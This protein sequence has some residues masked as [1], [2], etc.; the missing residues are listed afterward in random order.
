MSASLP[1]S[2][3]ILAI[4]APVL[5]LSSCRGA[6]TLTLEERLNNPLFSEY[7]YDDLVQRMV[8]IEIGSERKDNAELLGDSAR[9]S[10]MDETRRSALAAAKE[11]VGRQAE[12]RIG[13]FIPV[14]EFVKG[15]VLLLPEALYFGPD[16]DAS[17]GPQLHLFLTTAVDPRDST[18]PDETAID[19][20]RL[21]N[22]YGAHEHSL[23]TLENRDA[24]RTVVLFDS[25][26]QRLYGFAQLRQP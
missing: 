5:L 10:I 26:L 4:L 13:S 3:R 22:A 2:F 6:R 20:G 17:P 15:E 16:F 8:D 24:L 25:A 12:G 21:E 23:P 19:I 11:A 18:F 9:K 1:F 14:A 7:Y